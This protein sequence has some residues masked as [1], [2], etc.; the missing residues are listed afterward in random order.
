MLNNFNVYGPNSFPP[1]V[2]PCSLVSELV[3]LVTQL[4]ID[5]QGTIG[6]YSGNESP[7]P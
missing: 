6:H 4:D 7:P 3:L 2:S 5:Q 1:Q